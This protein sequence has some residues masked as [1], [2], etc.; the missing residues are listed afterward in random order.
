M[1]KHG[2]KTNPVFRFHR[3]QKHV[4][5]QT[6]N[7]C[8]FLKEAKLRLKVEKSTWAPR[9]CMLRMMLKKRFYSHGVARGFIFLIFLALGF[10]SWQFFQTA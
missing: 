2:L 4:L 5:S 3:L 8:F 10:C 1:G 7:L 6:K 9:A